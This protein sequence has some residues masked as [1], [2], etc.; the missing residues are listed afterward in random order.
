MI[1]APCILVAFF[2]MLVHLHTTGYPGHWLSTVLCSIL[3]NSMTT[4]ARPPEPAP[5]PIDEVEA[6]RPAIHMTTAPYMAEMSTLTDIHQPLL[7][8]A[9]ADSELPKLRTLCKYT[10]QFKAV[11]RDI[12]SD[13]SRREFMLCFFK[14]PLMDEAINL[15]QLSC[16]QYIRDFLVSSEFNDK[17]PCSPAMLTAWRWDSASQTATFWLR[18]DVFDE[19]LRD[20]GQWGCGIYRTDSWTTAIDERVGI[21]T[22]VSKGKR[23]TDWTPASLQ[24]LPLRNAKSAGKQKVNQPPHRASDPI[25]GRH[26]LGLLWEDVEMYLVSWD[27]RSTHL[28]LPQPSKPISPHWPPSSSACPAPSAPFQAALHLPQSSAYSAS[29]HPSSTSPA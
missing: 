1:H 5:L 13:N 4:S 25:V 10:V 17:Y 27:L 15:A 26:S 2:R 24:A 20:S 14:V 29:P 7:P 23:W 19:M 8:F 12:S 9:L 18:E 3:A 22:T 21:N 28:L 16:R 11:K 6:Q